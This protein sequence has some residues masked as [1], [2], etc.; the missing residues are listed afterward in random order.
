M[1]T[2]RAGMNSCRKKA[3]RHRNSKS[4]HC[5]ILVKPTNACQVELPAGSRTVAVQR[6]PHPTDT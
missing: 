2:L 4:F 5:S 1:W 3:R 6:T